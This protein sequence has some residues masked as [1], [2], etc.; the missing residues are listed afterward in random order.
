MHLR[1]NGGYFFYLSSLLSVGHLD[2]DADPPKR[3]LVQAPFEDKGHTSVDKGHEKLLAVRNFS[4]RAVDSYVQVELAI[5]GFTDCQVP[6]EVSA[7]LLISADVSWKGQ[8][9]QLQLCFDRCTEV[10]AW[11]LTFNFQVLD[12]ELFHGIG[13][14]QADPSR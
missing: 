2:A 13:T 12:G 8:C 1:S 11:Y 5:N 7:E 14:L 10:V 9:L 4:V 3:Q 6:Q